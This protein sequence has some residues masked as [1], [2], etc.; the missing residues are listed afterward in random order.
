MNTYSTSLGER[1]TQSQIDSRIRKAKAEKLRQQSEEH[2]YNFCTICRR[3]DCKPLDCSHNISV[4]KA[5]EEGMA[6]LCWDLE[7]IEIIGRAHHQVKDGLD[8][9]F[10]KQ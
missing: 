3:N 8:L 6:E 1:L 4:K 9:Q 2:G 7:N 5:K 10:K